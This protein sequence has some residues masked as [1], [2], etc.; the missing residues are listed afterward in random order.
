[1][2]KAIILFVFLTITLFSYAIQENYTLIN[3]E[4]IISG[5]DIKFNSNELYNDEY[6][7]LIFDTIT[8][9]V[10]K[11]EDYNEFSYN[12]GDFF[13]NYFI[14]EGS[15]ISTGVLIKEKTQT[16]AKKLHD[17]KSGLSNYM[18]DKKDS[19]LGFKLG[20]VIDISEFEKNNYSDKKVLIKRLNENLTAIWYQYGNIKIYTLFLKNKNR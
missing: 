7:K 2:K 11:N 14:G 19:N 1:M 18:E 16:I 9:I 12:S 4:V 10:D 5:D 8:G 3:F 15:S 13:L 17:L 6:Y 20:D